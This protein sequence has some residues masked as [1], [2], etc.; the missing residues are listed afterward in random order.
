M[1][2]RQISLVILFFLLAPLVASAGPAVRQWQ[3]GE[4][5]SRKTVP[6]GRTFTRNEYIYRVRGFNCRYVV[7]SKTPL[8]LDLY[9]P[10]KFSVD[11][12]HLLIQDADG[13]ELQAHILRK[14]AAARHR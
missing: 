1:R 14:A 10:M 11:R 13:R 6:M 8:G 12:K 4:L 2:G 9:E 5:L 3:D 7:V